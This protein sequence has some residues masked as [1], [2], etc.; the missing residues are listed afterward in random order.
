MYKKGWMK[1]RKEGRAIFTP[2]VVMLLLSVGV[3]ALSG[4]SGNS[5]A[6]TPD[7]CPNTD[8]DIPGTGLFRGLSWGNEEIIEDDIDVDEKNVDITNVVYNFSYFDY[9]GQIKKAGLHD[10]YTY[11]VAAWQE[12]EG[13]EPSRVFFCVLYNPG[14]EKS[15]PIEVDS[16]SED[17]KVAP[18]VTAYV[19]D[20]YGYDF[21]VVSVV[22]Q[23]FVNG[24]WQIWHARYKQ[25]VPEPD[26]WFVAVGQPELIFGDNEANYK[27]P[28][29]VYDWEPYGVSPERLHVVCERRN[30]LYNWD[31]YYRGANDY[32]EVIEWDPYPR[33]VY[34]GGW[35]WRPRI[36]AGF[37]DTYFQQYF[38]AWGAHY[39]GVVWQLVSPVPEGWT[40]NVKYTGFNSGG[41]ANPIVWALT[42]VG[43]N[44]YN[45]F[46]SIEIEPIENYPDHYR[47]TFVVWTHTVYEPIPNDFPIAQ[48]HSLN[49]FQ[50]TFAAPP[51]GLNWP[52]PA[53]EL[54]VD[55]PGGRNG[56]P[57][58]AIRA[59]GST[60]GNIAW[61]H[62][63]Y[64]GPPIVQ[65]WG[66]DIWWDTSSPYTVM[67]LYPEF[68]W[69]SSSYDPPYI[70]GP[71][72]ATFNLADAKC[73]WTDKQLVDIGPPP[74]YD[75]GIHGN[76]EP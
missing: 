33:P 29:I 42:D 63:V 53:T 76:T 10:Q 46:P 1:R 26:F 73:I 37:D 12:K 14:N 25:T 31:I 17:E 59:D 65:V 58:F 61:L 69:G 74:V 6:V 47:T 51:G 56:F 3:L 43:L 39:I 40:V 45:L 75:F 27:Y 55:D 7:P 52:P 68:I 50:M 21:L 4:C 60:T 15:A 49:T 11:T 34:S 22:Y 30:S 23:K 57:T 9:E 41:P 18:A 16:G 36:D 70:F 54:F 38:G 20:Y 66:G 19:T 13:D 8:N 64:Q 5:H 44:V 72:I 2:W 67:P 28:D 35:N 62:D 24:R 71:E 32:I 48:I